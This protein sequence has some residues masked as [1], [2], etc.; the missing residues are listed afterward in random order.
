MTSFLFVAPAVAPFGEAV[1]GREL[2]VAAHVAGHQVAFLHSSKIA[3]VFEGAPFK[4]GILDDV[5]P[6]L[7]SAVRDAVRARN[8]DV[9]VLVDALA[10]YGV[11]GASTRAFVE[12]CGTKVIALDLW[13]CRET[14]LGCDMGETEVRLDSVL[15]E[16]P[17]V[18]PAPVA[19]PDAPGA[20]RAIPDLAERMGDRASTRARLGI[21]EHERVVF[22]A[23][24]TWQSPTKYPPAS[25]MHRIADAWPSALALVLRRLRDVRVLHVGPRPMPLEGSYLHVSQ[26]PPEEFH[27]LLV[28]SDVA[29]GNNVMATSIASALALDVAC[30]VVESTRAC[31]TIDEAGAVPEDV[32]RWLSSVVPLYPYAV[33]PLGLRRFV[34]PILAG[35]PFADAIDRCD[36]LDPDATAARVAALLERDPKK[37][38][39][40]ASYRA[41]IAALPS[42]L[43]Q[44]TRLLDRPGP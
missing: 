32:R 22:T 39:A 18:R 43:E 25:A 15:V 14:D 16:L 17:T 33:L 34:T 26:V 42:G 40:R 8:V 11:L 35:N 21:G 37:R 27:R 24:G 13:G 7:A 38:D 29:I 19:R 28:A 1:M 4:R 6:T 44:L 30:V 36:I 10:T 12:S 20:Y 41:Q 5:L 3:P 23:T 9:V 31:M 2:A